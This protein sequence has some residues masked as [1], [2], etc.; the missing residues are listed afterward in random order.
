MFTAS[1]SVSGW[2]KSYIKIGKVVETRQFPGDVI[3]EKRTNE[4][5]N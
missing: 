5:I 3:V 4:N 1:T 2:Q